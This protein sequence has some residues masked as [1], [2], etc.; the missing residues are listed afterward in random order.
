RVP[1]K[2]ELKPFLNQ[3]IVGLKKGMSYC[4]CKDI[5]ALRN[6]KKFVRMTVAGLKE[7]HVHDVTI[8]KE[9]PNYTK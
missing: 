9:P 7:S 3:L 2:G 4:G 6:Y 1:Y 5:E 8:A